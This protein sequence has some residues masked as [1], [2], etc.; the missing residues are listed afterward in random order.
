MDIVFSFLVHVEYI[1]SS[2]TG[3]FLERALADAGFRATS[4]EA[5]EVKDEGVSLTKTGVLSIQFKEAKKFVVP[6]YLF[7]SY[8]QLLSD[9]QVVK[10]GTRYIDVGG[11]SKRRLNE[12]RLLKSV[13]DYIGPQDADF[14]EHILV[15]RRWR[16]EDSKR[17]GTTIY[18][19]NLF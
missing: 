3:D 4:N 14:Y 13:F 6:W 10:L 7:R 15:D 12:E 17:L 1:P 19:Y 8:Q 18:S 5:I 9:G 16:F 2:W 11:E